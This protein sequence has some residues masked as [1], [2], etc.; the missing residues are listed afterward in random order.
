MFQNIMGLQF[1][2]IHSYL[3]TG[4][5][6]IYNKLNTDKLSPNLLSPNLLSPNLLSPI[7]EYKEPDKLLELVS[8]YDNMKTG[9]GYSKESKV[10]DMIG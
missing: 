9:V 7:E 6:D 5:M 4:T 2:H 1:L 3:L 8:I 10:E